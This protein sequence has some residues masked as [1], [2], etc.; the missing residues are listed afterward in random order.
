MI[1]ALSLLSTDL[2]L[3]TADEMGPSA[4]L[5][6]MRS[7]SLMP[8]KDVCGAQR[9]TSVYIGAPNSDATSIAELILRELCSIGFPKKL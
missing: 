4:L 8:S 7:C 5:P 2:L 1:L 3:R 9:H 6:G